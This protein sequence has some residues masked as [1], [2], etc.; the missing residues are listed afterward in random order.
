M[1]SSKLPIGIRYT[2]D[3]SA[4]LKSAVIL[5]GLNSYGNT[6]IK[7]HILSRDHTENLLQDNTQAIKINNKRGKTITVFGKRNL[8]PFNITVGGDP[9]GCIFRCLN[10]ASKRFVAK[11][12][13]CWSQSD[14]NR[15]F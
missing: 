9:S 7:E 14:K 11:D 8:S 12:K 5:A 3:V 6:T 2:A 13:K 4:Q 1:I 10:A 15:I